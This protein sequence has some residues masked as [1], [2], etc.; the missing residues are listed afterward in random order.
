MH[1]VTVVWGEEYTRFYLNVCLPT[2]LSEGNIQLVGQRAQAIYKIVTTKQDRKVIESSIIYQKLASLIKV[3]FVDLAL[4]KSEN[5]YEL[6]TQSYALTLDAANQLDVPL[7]FLTPDQAM[8]QNTFK[9]LEEVLQRGKRAVF[10]ST[11]RLAK[12]GFVADLKQKYGTESVFGITSRDLVKIALKN[13]HK[14]SKES[15]FGKTLTAWPSHIYWDCGENTLLAR[16]FHLHPLLI[17]PENKLARLKDSIDGKFSML[18]CPNPATWEIIQDSDDIAMFELSGP[19]ACQE[20]ATEPTSLL[21]MSYWVKDKAAQSHC[22]F[23]HFANCVHSEEISSKYYL[24]SRQSERI[25]KQILSYVHKPNFL[26]YFFWAFY[27]F[28]DPLVNNQQRYFR[29]KQFIKKRIKKALSFA[30]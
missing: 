2:Q 28:K 17:W 27:Y 22:Y 13:L 23:I 24:V 1:I 25:I 16:G 20:H 12:E 10:I 14:I 8:S 19:Q 7:V 4:V 26:V 6:M 21:R 3:E 9:Y 11:I 5:K 30:T 15:F 29:I 18:A